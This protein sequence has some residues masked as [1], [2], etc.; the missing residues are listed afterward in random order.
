M[1]STDLALGV[2]F[3]TSGARAMV[4]NATGKI[5]AES[6][7]AFDS[8]E[9]ANSIAWRQVLYQL[10]KAIP[11]KGRSHIT[12]IAINGTSATVL[13][14]DAQQIPIGPALLYN[15]TRARDALPQVQQVAPQGSPTISATSSLTK[16][17]W[18]FQ[19]LA[20]DVKSRVSQLAH[21]ADWLAAQ[22]HGREPV[23]DYHNALKLGY[24]VRRLCYPNWLR[25]LPIANWL[26]E[27]VE[28]GRAIAPI[29]PS[30]ATELSLPKTC[31]ICAGTT[32]SIAAFLASGATKP[33]QAV[34]SLGSTLV[35]KLLSHQPVDNQTF[36]IYSHRLG[37][38]WLAGGASNTGGAVLKRFFSSDQIAQLSAQIDLSNPNS[39][40]YY[41]LNSPGER[42]PLNDPDY[43]PRLTP[44]PVDDVTFLY[45]L[46]DS[47]ARIEAEG[48]RRLG[49]LGA[50][51]VSFIY[52]AGGGAKNEIW[53]SLRQRRTD[54][55]VISAPQTE[56]AYGTA[57]LAMQGLS[58]FQ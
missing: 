19:T 38:L 27:V 8:S 22:L 32:D 50:S 53:Q 48:Y 12:R 9:V 54:V 21:Q 43:P 41:P 45:G 6:R 2:D 15:D 14:C 56:A 42:F 25:A 35:L 51:E 26:P 44:R 39:L 10:I 30:I 5:I 49:E 28:P 16:A 1:F 11:H 3:G 31:Q 55:R 17:L 52:T 29:S 46:L 23:S 13:L 57:K 40:S 34:T 24:D 4:L 37:N 36:G 20:P 58:K 18:W 33:G 7:Y 47:M